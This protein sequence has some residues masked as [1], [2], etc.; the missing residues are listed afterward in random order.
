MHEHTK[1][2]LM[3]LLGIAAAASAIYI[4]F[5]LGVVVADWRGL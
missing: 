1:N 4:G 5:M 2:R 3:I